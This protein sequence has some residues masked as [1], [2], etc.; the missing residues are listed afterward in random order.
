M[1]SKSKFYDEIGVI[2]ISEFE[3]RRVEKMIEMVKN[4]PISN[5]IDLGC[6]PPMSEYFAK[7]LS[8]EGVGVNVSKRVFTNLRNV[9][10]RVKYV[11]ADVEKVV[12][13]KKFDLVVCGELIEHIFDVDSFMKKIKRILHENGYLLLTTPNLASLINRIS[14]LLGWQPRGINPSRRVLLNPIT[15]HDYNWGHVSM[16]TLHALKKFLKFY[17]FEILKIS[18]ISCTHKGENLLVK[19]IRGFISKIPSLAE[20][21]IVLA[22]INRKR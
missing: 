8:C 19:S 13:R 22:K 18:G 3:K 10:K 1:K 21:V 9:S 7:K 2:G 20:N 17:R 15:K 12:L 16:F 11:V 6:L 5:F 4:L 14:L